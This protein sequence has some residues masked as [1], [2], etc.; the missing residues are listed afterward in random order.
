MPFWH[1]SASV[2]LPVAD[3]PMTTATM[4]ICPSL[5]ATARAVYRDL[6][7]AAATTF[8]GAIYCSSFASLPDSHANFQ[9]ICL[10]SLVRDFRLSSAYICDVFGPAF[11]EKV[12]IETRQGK[13]VE[14][15]TAYA[16]RLELGREI[17]EVLRKNVVQAQRVKEDTGEQDVW[18]TSG[19][20][21]SLMK[22]MT[23]RPA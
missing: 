9:M 3:G 13:S 12:R 6:F 16:K 14:D 23:R 4:S 22:L 21:C 11:K 1:S 5:R 7:R 8:A 15:A 19:S 10:F 2:F 20:I 18:S 17:A